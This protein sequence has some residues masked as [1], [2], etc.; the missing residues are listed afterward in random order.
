MLSDRTPDP[1]VM[2]P[3]S[4]DITAV[5][6]DCVILVAR[7]VPYCVFICYYFMYYSIIAP[8]FE[9]YKSQSRSVSQHIPSKHSKEM[10]LQSEVVSKCYMQKCVN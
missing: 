10:A 3:S 4:L 5:T 6:N 8:Y 7:Y 1:N 2:L 9:E